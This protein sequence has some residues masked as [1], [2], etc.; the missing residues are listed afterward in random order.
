MRKMSPDNLVVLYKISKFYIMN[1][2]KHIQSLGFYLV[3]Y[4]AVIF[5][6]FINVSFVSA[7]T[8]APQF[9]VTWN[10]Q[11][12]VPPNYQGKTF[13]TNGS[14][15]IVSFELVSQGK[16]IDLSGQTINWYLDG[17][18]FSGGIGIQSI[19]FN[20][21]APAGTEHSVNIQLPDY[22][23]EFLT[24]TINIPVLQ[25]QA[26][27]EAPFPGKIFSASNLQ[28][29]ARPYFFNIGDP[30]TLIFSWEVNGANPTNAD[31]PDTLNLNLKPNLPSDFFLNIDLSIK[32]PNDENEQA[33]QNISL[34]HGR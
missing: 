14:P 25:S 13:P 32:N 34:N 31:Q 8:A 15:V 17:D 6:L 10:A 30:S 20:A 9:L 7:Q 3:I 26:V 1:K 18:F 23:G 19:N 24:K 28:L 12:Y 11:S 29:I 16:A 33:D 27:I 5:T 4:F 21:V 22:Q 2:M